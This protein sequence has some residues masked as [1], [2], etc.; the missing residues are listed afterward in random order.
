MTH[1][2][3]AER[4]PIYRRQLRGAIGTRKRFCIQLLSTGQ[5]LVLPVPMAS[6]SNGQ[7]LADLTPVSP[8]Q[9]GQ[10]VNARGQRLHTVLY[11]SPA[12]RAAL[13]WHHGYGEHVGRMKYGEQPL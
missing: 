10:R 13:V 7:V 3:W 12:P 8:F 11:V 6:P 9:E 5:S 2:S 1:N 4:I